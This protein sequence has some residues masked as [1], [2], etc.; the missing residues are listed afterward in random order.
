LVDAENAPGTVAEPAGLELVV[1]A[2][3][4][5][6]AGVVSLVVT[7]EAPLLEVWAERGSNFKPTFFMMGHQ[8][9]VLWLV[10][11]AELLKQKRHMP[12]LCKQP[13]AND[14]FDN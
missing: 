10:L 14:S 2:G 6:G 7:W 12:L 5:G 8:L 4:G 3:G 1:E 11:C 13:S 9:H